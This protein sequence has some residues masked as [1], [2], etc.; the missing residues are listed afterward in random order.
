MNL[1]LGLAWGALALATGLNAL[2][3]VLVKTASA[4]AAGVSAPAAA[5]LLVEPWFV[6]G[7][8][9]FGVALVFYTLALSRLEISV[10]YPVLTG[11]GF[12]I[13]TLWAI[14]HLHES[15]TGLKL[16]GAALVLAGIVLLAR[17]A[18]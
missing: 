5:R 8:A 18:E 16:A 4:R 7:V 15:L 17:P 2:A 11:V 1:A 10:A 14:L 6:A 9:S 13:V 3:N 12:L